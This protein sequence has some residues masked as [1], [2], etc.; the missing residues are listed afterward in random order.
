MLLNDLIK[1]R[2]FATATPYDEMILKE[3]LFG[4]LIEEVKIYE[5]MDN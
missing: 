2:L 5:L 1:Y 4:K 3:N